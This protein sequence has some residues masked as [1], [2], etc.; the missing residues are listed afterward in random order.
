MVTTC[1][2]V[3]G[4]RGPGSALTHLDGCLMLFCSVVCWRVW[5]EEVKRERTEREKWARGDF[6]SGSK[7][8]KG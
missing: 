5:V 3:E 2:K 6:L 8:V 1:S 7:R 4:T